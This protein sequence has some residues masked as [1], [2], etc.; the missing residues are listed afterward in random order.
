MK[1][2]PPLVLVEAR[3]ARR[4]P[5][6]GT[7]RYIDELRAAIDAVAP[8]DLRIRWLLGPP[9]VPRRGRFTG[10]IN[11]ALDVLW[12]HVAV[13]IVALASQASL[14]HGTF[15]WLPVLSP[16]STSVTIQDLAWERMPEAFE[17]GFRR[18]ATRFT[19]MAARRASIVVVPSRSTGDDVTAF[20]GTDPSRIRVAPLA[21]T[22]HGSANVAREPFILAVGANE[23]RKRIVE[24]I[25]AHR[26]Y[27]EAAGPGPES[28]R[29]IV[30]GDAGGLDGELRAAAGPGCE[31]RG[32]V[33]EPELASLYERAAL[34]V[35]PSAYEGFGLPILE[36]MSYGC[37][38]L[39]ARNS[40]L[41]EAG[42]DVAL[43]LDDMSPDAFARCL[44][45]VLASR[46][47]LVEL[48]ERSREHAATFTWERTARATLDAMRE[49]LR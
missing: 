42:G 8:S 1:A 44:G 9:G 10:V 14:I 38:V 28:C 19:R 23:P 13:P 4:R 16:T 39:T 15:N 7:A 34:M 32:V 18:F 41:P 33:S 45:E 40:S 46:T 35:Y 49:A 2:A 29:L 25:R 37:P 31:L 21:P 17:P 12:M 24:L 43:Y 48:G 36:A 20:Y 11:A 26:R 30:V 3:M 6:T 27:F 22:R 47:A 5:A